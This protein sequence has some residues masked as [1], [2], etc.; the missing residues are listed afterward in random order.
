MLLTLGLTA[1]VAGFT[2]LTTRMVIVRSRQL[3]TAQ[4]GL[5]KAKDRDT[6]VR[7]ADTSLLAAQAEAR[8]QEARLELARFRAPRLL[9]FE[10]QKRIA[11][12][13]SGLEKNQDIW[14]TA[15]PVTVET[16]AL[17]EQ[18]LAAVKIAVPGAHWF[19]GG[20]EIGPT[21]KTSAVSGV[22]VFATRDARS[23]QLANVLVNA[24]TAEGIKASSSTTLL[25][26]ENVKAD[27]NDPYCF[28]VFIVV[29]PK[30]TSEELSD[31]QAER[32]GCKSG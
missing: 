9:D 18:I 17:A 13:L 15:A 7:I 19:P 24:L 27:P 8:A 30:G 23:I 1:L 10:Q 4:D 22:V 26:C 6:D 12:H 2:V 14:V 25:G 11:S 16:G 31:P 3:A 32:I 21:T 5:A 20:S 29:G 28:H